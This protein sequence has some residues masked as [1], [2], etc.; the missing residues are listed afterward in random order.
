MKRI[1]DIRQSIWG[2][3]ACE[4]SNKC[5]DSSGGSGDIKME[6][7]KNTQGGQCN[8]IGIN[9]MAGNAVYSD[10]AGQFAKGQKYGRD[11]WRKSAWRTFRRLIDAVNAAKGTGIPTPTICGAFGETRD[12]SSENPAYRQNRVVQL[13][14]DG[15]CCKIDCKVYVAA[16]FRGGKRARQILRM[17]KA[18][19]DWAVENLKIAAEYAQDKGIKLAIEPLNRF[20]NRFYQYGGRWDWS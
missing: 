13:K 18:A 16:V 2:S 8:E 12:V 1:T 7:V 17:K 3:R 14:D 15:F 20:G 9:S 4:F 19:M 11:I 5:V 10:P 6:K